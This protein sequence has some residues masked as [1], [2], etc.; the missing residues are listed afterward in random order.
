[1]NY[2]LSDLAQSLGRW[3]AEQCADGLPGHFG[4][5][6]LERFPDEDSLAIGI[7]L[8]ELEADGLVTLSHVI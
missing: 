4:E 3:M 5:K 2:D 1:M 6:L 7:A 8:A